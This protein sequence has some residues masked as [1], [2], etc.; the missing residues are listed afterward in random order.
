[1]YICIY[2][3]GKTMTTQTQ[4]TKQ[5]VTIEKWIGETQSWYWIVD[6]NGVGI[7]GFSKKHQALDAIARWGMTRA[8]K[9]IKVRK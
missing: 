3:N 8:N 2:Q 6:C 5:V 1:M 7:D 4:N 9:A